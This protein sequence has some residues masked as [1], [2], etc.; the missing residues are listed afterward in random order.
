MAQ[1]SDKTEKS[2]RYKFVATTF[3]GL[4]NV[5]AQEIL[6]LG[7]DDVRVGLRAVCFSGDMK[8]MYRANYFLRTALRVLL[9]VETFKIRSADD[10]YFKS[11]NIFW[12]KYFTLDQSFAI[13]HTVFSNLFRNSMFASLKVKDAIVDRFRQKFQKR[14]SV[15]PRNPDIHV[16][17]HIENDVCTISLDSSGE[18]LHKRG[19]RVG[20]TEAPINEVLAAGLLK[21]SE[22]DGCQ[23]FFDPMCGSGTIAIEAALLATNTP[24]GVIRERFA[25]QKWKTYKKDLFM[26]L[27][28][29]INIQ[30]PK[31]KIVASD[32]ARQ[33]IS[34]ALKN[35]EA[36]GVERIVDFKVSGFE[37]FD[38]GM[39]NPF[40]LFNPPYGERLN[41]G[42]AEFYSMVGE[43]LKHHYTNAT[44]WII[45][46]PECL[47]SIG[48]KPSRKVS[49]LNGDINCSF[50]KYEL[51]QGSKKLQ[52]N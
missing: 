3:A 2:E 47:K 37:D 50:R 29:E 25:F 43:R 13:H 11:K 45:S 28:D 16:N 48:L 4:E 21:I 14:P 8:M 9:P 23:D 33:A 35:A 31:G 36:A 52:N 46:T 1:E 34:I 40:L 32:I 12:E 26:E 19:Y 38:P 10:L 49:L 30:E 5:L 17:L 6:E 41:A 27:M 15:D 7:A 20:Q 51:Y 39:E 42:N 18:S 44:A 24:P 22:W